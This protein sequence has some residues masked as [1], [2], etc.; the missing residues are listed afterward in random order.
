[1]SAIFSRYLLP[2]TLREIKGGNVWHTGDGQSYHPPD[3]WVGIHLRVAVQ[4]SVVDTE[5]ERG[6]FLPYDDQRRGPVAG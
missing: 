4:A 6:V 1:M 5:L 2:V 3:A